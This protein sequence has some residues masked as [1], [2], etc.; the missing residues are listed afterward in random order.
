MTDLAESKQDVTPTPWLKLFGGIWLRPAATFHR[1]REHGGRGWM[2]TAVLAIILTTLPV[3][4][5]GPLL[6][7]QAQE[8]FL[9]AQSQFEAPPGVEVQQDIPDVIGSPLFTVALPA[10]GKL[11]GVV[12]GWLLWGAAIHLISMMSGGRNSFWQVLQTAVWAYLPLTLRDLIQTIYILISGQLIQNPGLS[13]FAP[14][15]TTNFTTASTSQIMLN[16]LLSRID[17]YYFWNLALLIIGIAIMAQFTRRKALGVV[18]IVW[19]V[20]TLLSLL[21]SLLVG[22]FS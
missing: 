1:I 20:F 19:A 11:F 22:G 17:L 12:I 21:P 9:A 7:A 2:I 10:V 16:S 18:L 13:G 15:D 5:A 6:Q 14:L 8:A 4:V 3:L